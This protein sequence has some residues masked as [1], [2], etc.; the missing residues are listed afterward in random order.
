MVLCWTG[1]LAIHI[2]NADS[3]INCCLYRN[4]HSHVACPIFEEIN[5]IPNVIFAST[6]EYTGFEYGKDRVNSATFFD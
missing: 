3:D 1:S 2:C 6:F 4:H 5:V